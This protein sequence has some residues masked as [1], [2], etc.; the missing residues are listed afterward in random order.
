[1]SRSVRAG[2]A[3]CL[4]AAAACGT[5]SQA[6]PPAVVDHLQVS[7]QFRSYHVPGL[8]G[9]M[10]SL[11][12]A[13]GGVY[14]VC[15]P[16]NVY[17]FVRGA[18]GYSVS[19][20]TRPSVPAWN[21]I[22]L[23]YRDGVLYV[24]NGNGRDVLALRE[25]GT[26]LTLLRRITNTTMHDAHSVVAEADGSIEVAD[27]G[28]GAILR[29]RPDGTL[30]WRTA[31]QG[32]YALTGAGGHLYASSVVDHRIHELDSSGKMIRSAGGLGVTRGRYLLPVGLAADGSRILVTDAHNGDVTVLG[33]DLAVQ[34]RVGGNGQGLD[35]FNFPFEAVPVADG[36]LVAD[37]FKYR[38]VH[39][40]SSWNETE[41]ISFGPMVPVGRGRP[42]VVGTDSH[43]YTYP[44]L[45]GVDLLAALGLRRSE[46][47]VGAL[48]GL[49]HVDARGNVSHLD[50]V[51]TQFGSTSLT[52]AQPVGP[53]IVIGSDQ[54][55]AIE[56][57]DPA[58]GMFTFVEVGSDSWWRSG[59]LLLS[60][61]L[62]VD[63][64]QVIAPAVA[65]FQKAKLLLT[66]GVSRANAFNQA[67]TAGGKLRNWSTDLSSV[68]G[69]QFL[70]S[71][72]TGDDARRYF[73]VALAQSQ[74]R[75]MEVL[76]VKY[77]SGV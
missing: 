75:M 24:A 49:D 32:A 9:L 3:I 21:P 38:L 14:L 39:T 35:A 70:H 27:E 30:Q 56:V 13:G 48:N 18:G 77:L 20:L 36:Y 15:D 29:F 33:T 60:E 50:V 5:N 53:Y 55:G 22:G 66:Q 1:M 4:L 54:R 19:R 26:T 69:Q 23:A 11:V 45:P 12:D 2:L 68:A 57:V 63:L 47:F 44:T 31:L 74:V 7:P 67:L 52:W 62:R 76:E 6:R 46:P 71:Q 65:A 59:T 40:D 25:E 73:N 28:G 37:T 43:P 64:T 8:V 72:M 61:N 16:T 10:S 34:K 51:D 41:Q 58:T 17:R 42:L